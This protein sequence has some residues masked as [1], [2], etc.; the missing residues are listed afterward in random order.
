MG[1]EFDNNN[2]CGL[3]LDALCLQLADDPKRIEGEDEESPRSRDIEASE[4]DEDLEDQRRRRRA[5]RERRRSK[6]PSPSE[7]RGKRRG[8]AKDSKK[9]A[10]SPK[11]GIAFGLPFN[12]SLASDKQKSKTVTQKVDSNKQ[13]KA[14]E[15]DSESDESY[16]GRNISR[17]IQADVFM[18]SGCEGKSIKTELKTC[19]FVRGIYLLTFIAITCHRRQSN[20]GGCEQRCQFLAARSQWASWRCLYIS[21]AEG[22]VSSAIH[23]W[24]FAATSTNI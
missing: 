8:S 5:S 3:D 23:L 1:D 21:S 19:G 11:K 10:S 20:F 13:T 14:V 9:E 6:S 12:L 17:D 18:I 15:T 7:N 4:T 2:W 24:S 22:Y 16:A